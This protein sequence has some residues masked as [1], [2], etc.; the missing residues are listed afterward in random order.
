M[1]IVFY[2]TKNS[3]NPYASM[4]T[5][6]IEQVGF[7][8]INKEWNS[9]MELIFKSCFRALLRHDIVFH[10]NWLEDNASRKGLVAKIK[11][12]LLLL[13]FSTFH[14]LGGKIVWTMHNSKS[15][16]ST[17][18]YQEVFIK[19]ML[20]Y[21]DCVVVHCSESV[22]ILS[23]KYE[24]PS[25]QVLF[26]PHGNY[27]NEMEKHLK[28]SK[29][30][31]SKVHFLYFGMISQYKG[32]EK[33]IKAFNTPEIYE[34][35]DLKI[36][37]KVN[38]ASLKGN[39]EKLAENCNSIYLDLNFIPDNILGEYIS[40]ADIIVLPYEKESMQNSGVAIMA[41]SCGKPIVSSQFGYIKDIA[42][43]NF[44]FSYDYSSE[45]NQI[46]I[47]RR[48]LMEIC[49]LEEDSPNYLK[50]IGKSAEQFSKQE[51]D[52]NLIAKKITNRYLQLF[53]I[54]VN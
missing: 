18:D 53:E 35:A 10:F 39:I 37:G 49:K 22:T 9:D 5:S 21:I 8:V 17:C 42:D 28:E 15:H 41:L 43:K 34:K 38:N 1:E 23:E 6:A 14:K 50:K 44:V 31:S 30:D 51:L 29:N 32:V 40:D 12:K 45:E 33:L 36:C 25:N 48:T 19:K 27:C 20:R 3:T 16:N 54:R 13:F 24:Y 26:V 47:L 46:K 11:C 52:W 4:S 7:K 2:P